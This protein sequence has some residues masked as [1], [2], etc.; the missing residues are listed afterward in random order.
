MRDQE[1]GAARHPAALILVHALSALLIAAALLLAFGRDWTG[2]RD[3]R[4]LLLQWHRW[5]GLTVLAL[6]LP[7]LCLRLLARAVPGPAEHNRLL[8]VAA[9]ACHGLLYA[10][11]LGLPVLGWMLSNAR[12]HAV[13]F[14]PLPLPTLLQRDREVADILATAHSVLGW[15]L[16]ALAALHVAAA[17]WHHWWKRDQILLRMLPAWPHPNRSDSIAMPMEKH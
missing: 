9:L 11:M 4:L 6:T 1:S 3:L 7:R 15:T 16:M 10:L 5:A 13:D 17:F 2:D 12:G 8:R 14:G